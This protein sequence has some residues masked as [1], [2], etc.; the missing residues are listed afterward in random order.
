VGDIIAGRTV[1]N[2]LANTLESNLKITLHRLIDWNSETLPG[3]DI[4][5]IKAMW[6]ELILGSS[7]PEL[8][9]WIIA[10]H[11]SLWINPQFCW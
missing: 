8:K 7:I 2:L 10:A 6:V 9:K 1:F 11:T 3:L 4:F 5:G